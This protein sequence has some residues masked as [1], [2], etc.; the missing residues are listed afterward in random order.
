MALEVLGAVGESLRMAFFMFWETLWPLILGFG[1]SGAVQ[2]FVSRS[3]ME[4]V[5]G[6]HRPRSLA[7]ATAL[8]AASSSCSYAATAVAK[9][10]FQKG[11]D[12][13]TTV[14]FMLA[15]TNL[16]IEL[17]LVL[18]ILIGW[19][20]AISEYVGG[21]V[22]IGL[23]ALVSRFFFRPRLLEA[24]RRRL[25]EGASS[26]ETGHEHHGAGS[27]PQ[28]RVRDRIRSRAGWADAASATMADLV[29]LRKELVIGY[30]VAGFIAVLVPAQV[31]HAVF[32]EGHGPL[33]SVENALIGPLIA[34]LSFVC[35][36][37]NVPLA[38]ALWQGGISFGGV[39][40]FI[41]ADLITL[42]LILIY[43]KFY[44][45]R[46]TLRLVAALWLVMAAAGLVTEALFSVAG[47]V[48]AVRPTQIAAP[49][50]TWN[51]TT[52]LNIAFLAVFAILYWLHRTRGRLHGGAGYAVDPMCGMQVET[53]TAP[54]TADHGG[55][56]YYF[57]SE[58]CRDHFLG[59]QGGPAPHPSP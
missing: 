10:L 37:G 32:F 59:P 1:L 33:T 23:L 9:S 40:S 6:D 43:R 50:L 41:F 58:D 24:A 15:S 36:I 11:A 56:R 46:L 45:G 5:M 7:L 52:F 34:V 17:G 14:V 31:W 51:Y 4:R 19:Q 30:A 18:W 16:V 12:F 38:A 29:M 28:G 27:A 35:S 48:P 25:E 3:D 42:P 13:T 53:A 39:V 8:G 21:I 26:M 22:M 2:A 20:F 55:E 54:A 47:L 57:C 44:G 49:E